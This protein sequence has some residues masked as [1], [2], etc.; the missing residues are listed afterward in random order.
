MCTRCLTEQYEYSTAEL[1][2]EHFTCPYCRGCGLGNGTAHAP[3]GPHSASSFS[4]GKADNVADRSTVPRK[5]SHDMHAGSNNSNALPLPMELQLSWPHTAPTADAL[6]IDGPDQPGQGSSKRPRTIASDR[7][8]PARG[9]PAV[10]NTGDS[11]ASLAV[12]QQPPQPPL[13]E[14]SEPV[15]EAARKFLD[16]VAGDDPGRQCRVTVGA[17]ISALAK[18]EVGIHAGSGD[19]A[20]TAAAVALSALE[21]LRREKEI[22]INVNAEAV[23]AASLTSILK[24][25]LLNLR[26]RRPKLLKGERVMVQGPGNLWVPAQVLRVTTRVPAR[27]SDAG[28][29]V[30]VE[31]NPIG[32]GPQSACAGSSAR[33]GSSTVCGA[34]EF[35][36]PPQ[37]QSQSEAEKQRQDQVMPMALLRYDGLGPEWDEWRP[38]QCS[39]KLVKIVNANA[40]GA[41][42]DGVSDNDDDDGM[43]SDCDALFTSD[44]EE[45]EQEAQQAKATAAENH[46]RNT[47]AAAAAAAA[48]EP[49]FDRGI[50]SA[51][52]T[53]AEESAAL[54]A[55]AA[56]LPYPVGTVVEARDLADKWF[57]ARMVKVDL[58]K[59]GNQPRKKRVLIHFIGWG[60]EWDE[61]FDLN[62]PTQ[63]ERLR[64]L[65]PTTQFGPYFHTIGQVGMWKAAYA[66][67]N[68]RNRILYVLQ[69]V[70]DTQKIGFDSLVRAVYEIT[71][72]MRP[73]EAM[74]IV[75]RVAKVLEELHE[76]GIVRW[77]SPIGFVYLLDV[78][79]H[80]ND[81]GGGGGGSPAT[82]GS[83]SKAAGTDASSSSDNA[84]AA[85]GDGAANSGRAAAASGRGGR[86]SAP[87]FKVGEV[88]EVLDGTMEW[89]MAT[90]I[91]LPT[92][93][94][95]SR[96]DGTGNGHDADATTQVVSVTESHLGYARCRFVGWSAEWDTWVPA[97]TASGDLPRIRVKSPSAKKKL[98]VAAA[99]GG[100]LMASGV[101]AGGHDMDLDESDELLPSPHGH[102]D[103]E[104]TS[105]SSSDSL[106]FSSN[107]RDAV[108]KEVANIVFGSAE[109]EARMRR[110]TRQTNKT[111]EE[112]IGTTRAEDVPI[113]VMDTHTIKNLGAF[114][115]H[116]IAKGAFI[117]EYAGEVT[118]LSAVRKRK[119]EY[120]FNLGSGL[121]IDASRQGNATR[122]MNHSSDEYACNVSAMIVNHRGTRRVVFHA[123]RPILCGEEMMYDYGE[124]FAK[125]IGKRLI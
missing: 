110:I 122:F 88:V 7:T 95:S 79:R 41:N 43:C 28:A 83:G 60:T 11:S 23:E 48:S 51:E 38:A 30:K 99:G 106:A 124:D 80:S 69:A 73:D 42:V 76:E 98:H 29:E 56:E 5:R 70:G 59:F 18:A 71:A 19:V 92:R 9:A 17:V 105:S 87:E 47:E 78:A 117:G 57:A 31:T 35:Q 109:V 40:G 107:Q 21:Y 65:T 39:A 84:A 44:E 119:S 20:K 6:N 100:A 32:A 24:I 1:Q 61:W 77:T 89:F 120:L 8:T 75:R 91:E 103:T 14:S 10:D 94:P 34:G 108:F 4:V 96:S 123:K 125:N 3:K 27:E 36:S 37:L 118:V 49:K 104:S 12:V 112:A 64:P 58:R 22:S 13:A 67:E 116:E 121:T 93:V 90:I 2:Q 45:E 16:D 26:V 68:Y 52:A 50:P 66:A 53:A 54:A 25:G 62:N 81:G 82:M 72:R 63:P 113:E 97:S 85:D 55:A 15:L 74:K 33:V 102:G 86:S 115:R 46:P 114:A 101:E 111:D